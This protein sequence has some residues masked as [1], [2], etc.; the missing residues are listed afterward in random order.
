M[1]ST[2]FEALYSETSTKLDALQAQLQSETKRLDDAARDLRRTLRPRAT[3]FNSK[4][5]LAVNEVID[6]FPLDA[7]ALKR[8]DDLAQEI[9]A[10]VGE[11]GQA[12][13]RLESE[14][15]QLE[16]EAALA[17]E[18]DRLSGLADDLAA[19]LAQIDLSFQQA[20]GLQQMIEEDGVDVGTGAVVGALGGWLTGGI[21][22]GAVSGYR[23]AGIKGAATGG[24]AGLVGSVGTVVAGA[25]A[26]AAL[27]LPLTW[28]VILPTMAVAGV[29][30]SLAGKW[31]TRLVFSQER[32]ER[33]REDVRVKVMEQLEEGSGQRVAD[34]G[35]VVDEQ[36]NIAYATLRAQVQ[37]N[38]GGPVE[39]TRQTLDELHA[40][41]SRTAAQRDHEL[42][43]LETLSKQMRA[44][45]GSTQQ[46]AQ[47][48][49]ASS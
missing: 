43:V 17:T 14:R 2:E 6:Q 31:M 12:V 49:R 9:V 10:A 32:A 11:R 20:S 24:A 41:S 22:G 45:L 36:I 18:L 19:Q 13:A 16:I 33:Y 23:E 21:L 1:A 38:F 47:A 28:P 7:K 26:I 34:F 15:V 4:L 5:V 39:A 46:V 3:Q 42:V 40:R 37:S 27:S 25:F 35:R 30:S 8:G 29:V 44:A 48:V